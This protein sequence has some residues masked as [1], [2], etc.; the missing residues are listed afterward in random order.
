MEKDKLNTVIFDLD[1]TLIDSM[2]IWTKVDVEFLKKRNISV[3]KNLF[4]D[5][6]GGNSF[7]EIAAYFK[8]KF[9]LPE[10]IS[11]IM[12]EW[13][14][15]VAQHYKTDV[16]L[17]AGVRKLLEFLKLKNV[18][19]GIG[20]SNNEYLTRTV[21]EAN[22]VLKFFDS[23][24]IGSDKIKG[25]PFPDIFLR[26][27]EELNAAPEKCLVIEDVLVGVRAAKNAG[28]KVFAIY[29]EY[30]VSEKES[31]RNIADFYAENFSQIQKKI[32][33]FFDE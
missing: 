8:K 3:P 6:E 16:K 19:M 22:G 18:K 25:K 9:K 1:G 26:V 14:Q 33:S 29:D 27:A 11:E 30:S 12:N 7:T 4:E 21:L 32:D 13:T 28:M 17:K 15:M 31:I 23:I 5:I 10:S 24:V 20:T 2:G